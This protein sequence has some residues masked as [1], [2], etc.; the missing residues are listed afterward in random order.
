MLASNSRAHKHPRPL[1]EASAHGTRP[2]HSARRSAKASGT[3]P[4]AHASS[5]H[6]LGHHCRGASPALAAKR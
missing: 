6:M 4:M 3:T 5:R 2:G 1:S